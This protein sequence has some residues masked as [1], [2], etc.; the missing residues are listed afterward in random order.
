MNIGIAIKSENVSHVDNAPL[1]TIY[2]APKFPCLKSISF[3]VDKQSIL[4]G[5]EDYLIENL[6][7][8]VSIKLII[9]DDSVSEFYANTFNSVKHCSITDLEFELSLDENG[10]PV[11]CIDK[12]YEICQTWN[13]HSLDL[14]LYNRLLSIQYQFKNPSK[15]RIE[16]ILQ[17]L[18]SGRN[19]SEVSTPSDYVKIE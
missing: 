19:L 11:K 7:E 5:K 2:L 4:F 16:E 13:L 8:H 14:Y 10:M 3:K 1:N 17:A 6:P 9:D 15:T 12:V 18:V